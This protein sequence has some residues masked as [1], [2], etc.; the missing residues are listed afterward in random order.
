MGEN[1]SCN[2][3]L[4]KILVSENCYLVFPTEKAIQVQ[5]LLNSSPKTFIFIDGT[6]RKAKKIFYLSENLHILPAVEIEGVLGDYQIR[7]AGQENYLSTIESVHYILS[8][9]EKK[10]YSKLLYPFESLKAKTLKFSDGKDCK[11]VK[12]SNQI[13]F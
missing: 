1:F 5:T 3:E 9:M 7:K 12:H 8:K 4:N 2:T 6:W 11:V 10:D 13:D